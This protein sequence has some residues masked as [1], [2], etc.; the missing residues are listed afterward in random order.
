MK[1]FRLPFQMTH[2]TQIDGQAVLN[3]GKKNAVSE[4]VIREL[5]DFFDPFNKRLARLLGD[6]KF[7]FTRRA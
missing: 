7:I 5:D 4:F 6:E 2:N 1:H 3:K